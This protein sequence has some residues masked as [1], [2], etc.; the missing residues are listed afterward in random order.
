MVTNQLADQSQTVSYLLDS[1]TTLTKQLNEVNG[2]NISVIDNEQSSSEDESNYEPTLPKQA[3]PMLVGLE[4][5]PP[6]ESARLLSLEQSSMQH[7]PSSSCKPNQTSRDY[8]SRQESS[9]RVVIQTSASRS[10]AR[11]VR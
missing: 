4:S 10:A 9:G 7:K 1:I 11:S 5:L 6:A 2:G 8:D 3:V